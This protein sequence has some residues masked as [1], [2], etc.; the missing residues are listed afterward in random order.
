M[1]CYNALIESPM[2]ENE[3]SSLLCRI[4]FPRRNSEQCF[5]GILASSDLIS[6]MKHLKLKEV[7]FVSLEICLGF[8]MKACKSVLILITIDVAFLFVICC[9]VQPKFARKD[10]QVMSVLKCQLVDIPTERI[11]HM[12]WV[13]TMILYIF[14]REAN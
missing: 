1:L 12:A 7:R 10:Y 9:Q 3:K 8:V 14:H 2:D 4:I 11:T 13:V 6:Q 5:L